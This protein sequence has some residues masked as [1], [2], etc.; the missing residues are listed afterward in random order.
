MTYS[1]VFRQSIEFVYRFLNDD[2]KA[3]FD[4]VGDI[5]DDIKIQF[6]TILS[7][8][9]A[10]QLTDDGLLT[11]YEALYQ[12]KSTGTSEQR[13]SRVIAAI[14]AKGGLNRSY[15]YTIADALGY[16]IGSGSKYIIIS[17]GDFTPWR[18]G[19]SKIGIDKIWPLSGSTT[20]YTVLVSGTD[21]ESDDDLQFQF[22]K[23]VCA[24]VS[25]VFQNI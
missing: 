19:I 21:V 16:S 2:L 25:F 10:F 23:Q 7:Q 11:E 20:M 18:V 6:D 4:V 17:E 1:D 13:I 22:Q 12:C 15:F 8:V 14:R 3:I 5:F 9:D 24:G